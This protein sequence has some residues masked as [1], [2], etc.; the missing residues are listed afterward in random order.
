MGDAALGAQDT[1]NCDVE[2]AGEVF[3]TAAVMTM[4]DQAA[5]PAAGTLHPVELKAA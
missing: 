3:H 1:L 2:K 4:P 5:F